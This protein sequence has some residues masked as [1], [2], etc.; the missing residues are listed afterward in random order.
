MGVLRALDIDKFAAH[1]LGI[2]SLFFRSET[3]ESGLGD[4]VIFQSADHVCSG[5]EFIETTIGGVAV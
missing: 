1:Y 5:T 2:G 3:V 4:T